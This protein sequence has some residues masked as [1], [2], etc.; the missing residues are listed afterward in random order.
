MGVAQSFLL[1]WPGWGGGGVLEVPVLVPVATS[2]V[3][4]SLSV[5]LG[6]E[7]IAIHPKKR[8]TARAV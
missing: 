4:R 3:A 5:R 8:A 6:G 7:S 2:G 1:L